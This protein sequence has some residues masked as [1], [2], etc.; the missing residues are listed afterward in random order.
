MNNNRQESRS[1]EDVVKMIDSGKLVLPEFQRDFKWSIE[2]SETL[3]DSIFQ[4]LFIGSLIIS[5]PKFDLACKGFDLRE[6]GK[7]SRKPVPR[8]YEKTEF[9]QNDIYTL[10]D[11]QQRTTAIYRALKGKDVIYI[12]FHDLQFLSSKECYDN[13]NNKI[14]VKHEKYIEGFDSSKPKEGEFYIK[15]CDLFTSIDYR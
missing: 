12:V 1:I 14:L 7:K 4:G 5:R 3:F 10:L 13:D 9:E 8:K 15:I 6:R 2:K 11:G